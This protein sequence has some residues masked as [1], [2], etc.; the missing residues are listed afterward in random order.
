MYRKIQYRS[1]NNLSHTHN[2]L[3]QTPKKKK[4]CHF[5]FVSAQSS[6]MSIHQKK[7]S[8]MSSIVCVITKLV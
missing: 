8:T 5:F 6:T 7:K 2:G 4:N 1:C 3:H